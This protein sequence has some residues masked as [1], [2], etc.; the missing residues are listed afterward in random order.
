MYNE[1]KYLIFCY[2]NI[3]ILLFLWYHTSHSTF[4]VGYVA[5]VA[6][7]EVHVAMED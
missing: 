7:D 5:L 3:L 6:G 2:K 1:L 4:G